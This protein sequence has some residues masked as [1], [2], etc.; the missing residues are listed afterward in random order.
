MS[1]LYSKLSL[2]TSKDILIILQVFLSTTSFILLLLL[3]NLLPKS[4]IVLPNFI[5]YFIQ[6]P[7]NQ[8]LQVW[9][10]QWRAEAISGP[11]STAVEVPALRQELV[12][13]FIFD[14]LNL[15]FCNIVS[16]LEGF[17]WADLGAAKFKEFLD[18]VNTSIIQI[19]AIN[20]HY[21]ILFWNSV[22]LVL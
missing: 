20:K 21:S 1:L 13:E 5:I 14:L 7:L 12:E 22:C 16:L 8:Q 15:L 18:Y 4:S 2:R 11:V 3:L 9:V 6:M 10:F 17:S 19:A